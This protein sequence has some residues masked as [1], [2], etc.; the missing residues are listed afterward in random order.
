M[1]T[2]EAAIVQL[3]V[4]AKRHSPSIIYIPSLIGW[5][6]AVSEIS[7]ST[8]RAMLDTLAPTD[9]VLL[10]AIVDGSFSSLPQDVRAWFGP[11]RD[12]RVA[13][14]S[15]TSCQRERFFE[16]L[17]QDIRRPPHAFADGI[18]RKKRVLEVLPIAPPL[19]PRQPTAA[20][21]ALQEENDQRVITLLK[22]RLGPILT[23]LKRKFKRFTKRAM[24]SVSFVPKRPLA[25]SIP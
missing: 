23:E 21:L 3:F 13:F 9:P 6:A 16:G 4:E 24:V 12:N 19:E 11:S 20:E 5:C 8:V 18:K 7:R 15:P 14:H 2:T 25:D 1:K 22:Y 17:L 10:L